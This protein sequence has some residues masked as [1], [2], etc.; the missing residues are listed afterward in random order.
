MVPTI[1][2]M[3]FQAV[4]VGQKLIE[5]G[6][7]SGGY[8]D[9]AGTPSTLLLEEIQF[10]DAA[11][12]SWIAELQKQGLT[13]STLIIITAKHGQSPVD[14][15]RYVGITA[16]GPVTTSPSM[17][18][19]NCL[20][21]SESNAGGQ[22]GPTEDDVSLLW[23]KKSCNTTSEVQI[24]E[25]Q[26]PTSANIAGIGQIFFGQSL[27]QL[28]NPPGI[29]PNGDPRTPDIIVAP[30]VGVTYSGSTSKQAEHGGFS[31]DDT[32]VIILVSNP[33]IPPFTITTPVQT[34]QVAPTIL[35]ALG[36]D[37][38]SLQGVQQQ[39]TQVLP[40]LFPLTK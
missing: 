30:N 10:V 19:D 40:G 25:S 27:N 14:S 32:N 36:L 28:F 7:G 38:G 16:S 13:D 15:Q 8:S 23:L 5:S 4:S 12:G 3:N 39:G 17:L 20:P 11:I 18:I 35:Q 34:A 1:F 29:P 6:A 21:A 37:P 33:S 31:H 9:A 22:I 24:L 26:S 2:G